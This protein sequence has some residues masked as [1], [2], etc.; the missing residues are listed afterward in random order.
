LAILVADTPPAVLKSPPANKLLPDNANERTW[1]FTPDPKADQL[2]SLK[3]EASD[4]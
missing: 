3:V 1:L 2:A 4:T